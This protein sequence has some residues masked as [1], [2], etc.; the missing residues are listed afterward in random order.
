[1]PNR[2]HSYY[3]MKG[4]LKDEDWRFFTQ[5]MYD[6]IDTLA[7]KLEEVIIKMKAHTVRQHQEVDLESIELL[8]LSA[9]RIK[10]LKGNSKHSRNS[11]KSRDS[12]IQSDGSSSENEKQASRRTNWKDTEEGY[13][14]YMVGHIA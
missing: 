7:N 6:K 1:M 12:G 9:T 14:C 4:I 5:L 3:Q 10:S 8:A 11:Q 2:E 13:R